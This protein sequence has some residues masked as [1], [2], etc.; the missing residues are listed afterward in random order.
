[1]DAAPMIDICRKRVPEE[2]DLDRGDRG[3]IKAVLVGAACVIFLLVL[4]GWL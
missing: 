3:T 1:M 2:F 4:V